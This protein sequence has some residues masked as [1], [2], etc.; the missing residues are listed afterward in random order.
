MMFYFE[1]S[2]PGT[3]TIQKDF[4]A[5][6]VS[7]LHSFHTKEDKNE[8]AIS[9]NRKNLNE[10]SALRTLRFKSKSKEAIEKFKSSDAKD[11][12]EWLNLPTDQKIL[13]EDIPS[14]NFGRLNMRGLNQSKF[15]KKVNFLMS[16]GA[17]NSIENAREAVK[18][19][20]I[21]KY[22][23]LKETSPYISLKM[24]SKSNNKSFSLNIAWTD[25][26]GDINS[27][28]LFKQE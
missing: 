5:K 16:K 17:F 8:I 27:Y 14:L 7:A 11:T 15:E 3:P 10:K 24:K 12:L 2:L 21:Q 4:L 1:V 18:E 13:E 22:K 28:G 26:N 23:S 20:Y 25:D 9:F 6:L 19:R